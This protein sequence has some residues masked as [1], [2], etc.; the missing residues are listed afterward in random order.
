M[1]N[2]SVCGLLGLALRASR[3]AVGDD[4]VHDLISAHHARAVFIASDAGAGIVKKI[5]YRTTEAG[6]PLLV[7]PETKAALGRALGRASCAV[8]ATSD[9]GFAASA[10]KKL[11]A[12]SAENAHA[13][14]LLD[15]KHTRME[16]RR[17][18][19]KKRDANHKPAQPM[20]YT[21]IE[22]EEYMRRFK[23]PE[24]PSSKGTKAPAP[25]RNRP[26]T[27]R[28]NRSHGNRK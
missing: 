28:W 9:I 27:E 17:T 1:E 21:D 20:E 13:A 23:K 3:L 7:L 4:P 16:E 10:A 5:K 22:E 15:K 24:K 18:R 25:Q 12:F 11:A 2:P 26:R 8:C 6:V 19:P 14:Q